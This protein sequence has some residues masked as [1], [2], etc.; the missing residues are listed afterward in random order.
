MAEFSHL[1]KIVML[2]PIIIKIVNKT[3]KYFTIPIHEFRQQ[4]QQQKNTDLTI[5]KLKV[6]L[7]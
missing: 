4:Q 7:K 1:M 5:N 2:L 3:R 6:K